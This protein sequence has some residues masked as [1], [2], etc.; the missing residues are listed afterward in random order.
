[1]A[2]NNIRE[3]RSVSIEELRTMEPPAPRIKLDEDMENW[4]Q[5]QSFLDYG[6]F[7]YR[8]NESVVG[9]TLPHSSIILSPVWFLLYFFV[10]QVQTKEPKSVVKTIALLETL[11]TWIDAIPPL[12]TP[13]RFGNLA[14]RTWGKRLEDVSLAVVLNLCIVY[15]IILSERG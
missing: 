10:G 1:M 4:K 11:D 9:H 5:S 12:E 13:Q 15:L 2:N 7:L 6:I 3:L 14:F 8:L